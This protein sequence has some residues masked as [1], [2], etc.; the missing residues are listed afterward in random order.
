MSLFAVRQ[1]RIGS[2]F[3]RKKSMPAPVPVLHLQ[4]EYLNEWGFY[5]GCKV[6]I[7]PETYGRFTVELTR[8]FAESKHPRD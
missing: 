7:V 3:K 5:P 2:F 6:Q 1:I 4:G 8:D